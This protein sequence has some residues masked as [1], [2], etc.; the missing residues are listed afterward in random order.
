M[1]ADR[2]AQRAAPS[3]KA[4]L[5]LRLPAEGGK[6]VESAYNAVTTAPGTLPVYIRFV[7]SGRL[8]KAPQEWN[9]TPT[10]PLLQELKRVLGEDN[11]AVVK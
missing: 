3:S 10:A 9:V 11:V 7:D 1:P 6:E 5:Y 4:G 2:D 8:V